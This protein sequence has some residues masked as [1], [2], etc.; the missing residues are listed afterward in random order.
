MNGFQSFQVIDRSYLPN[1]V[2]KCA[3]IFIA[4]LF[5]TAGIL[6]LIIQQPIGPTYGEA[7]KMLA[8]LQQDIFYKSVV[9]YTSTVLVM[10]AGIIVITL[11]YSHRV[12]GPVYRLGLFMSKVRE[13]EINSQVFLRQTDVIHPLAHEVNIMM[14][15]YSQTLQSINQELQQL[16]KHFDTLQAGQEASEETLKEIGERAG[17]ISRIISKYKL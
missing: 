14:E 12:V 2:L 6:Y 13:G 7:F 5:V 8:Q 4:G 1:V 17:E 15:E 16:E 10:L 9:I 3:L 11:L